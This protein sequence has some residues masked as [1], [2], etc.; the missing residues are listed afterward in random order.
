MIV[1]VL[2]LD[3]HG[4]SGQG[5][6]SD[7]CHADALGGGPP[8]VW[9]TNANGKKFRTA[10]RTWGVGSCSECV[11]RTVPSRSTGDRTPG[12]DRTPVRPRRRPVS[13]RAA[14]IAAAAVSV[15]VASLSIS[16]PTVGCDAT[17]PKSSG[18]A[19][20]TPILARQ[21]PAERDRRR[22]AGESSPA[23]A[24]PAASALGRARL[25]HAKERRSRAARRKLLP[26]LAAPL[27]R[28]QVSGFEL[29][30]DRPRVPRWQRLRN[31]PIA[32]S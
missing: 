10:V 13:T 21:S 17:G 30:A 23:H 11:I 4:L 7:G 3:V 8:R 27:F 18:W 31:C 9:S 2:N 5:Y 22:E 6:R 26:C 29:C 14:G 25:R 15:W 12:G 16:R 20:T 1:R 28:L 19:R 32:S 24:S